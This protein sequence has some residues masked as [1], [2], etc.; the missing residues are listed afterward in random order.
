MVNCSKCNKK[1][2]FLSSKNNIKDGSILCNSCFEKW[3]KEQKDKDKRIMMD[4]IGK[5]LS[6]KDMEMDGY[7]LGCHKNKNI[8][9]LFEENSL[10]KVTEHFQTLLSDAEYSNKSGMSSYDIDEVISTKKMCE[11]VLKFL[12]DLEK[13]YKL[14]NK[15][16]I[17][18]NYFEILSL[19]AENIEQNLNKE[20]DKILIPAHKRIIKRLGKNISSENVIKEFMKIPLN[21]EY[22]FDLISKLLDKFNLEYDKEE[23]EKIIE[24]AREEIGL[25]EFEQDLGSSQK[26]DIGDFDKLNGY[27]FEG[28][29]K[30]L[31]NL[32]GYTTIQTALSGD[33]GADLIISKDG[34]KTVVQAKKYNEKVPNKAIQEIVAAKNH[35]KANKAIVITNSSFTKSAID[36]ALSNNVELWDG[37]KLKDIIQNLKNKKKEKSLQSNKSLTLQKGKDIQ[38]IKVSCPFCEEEF[39]LKIDIREGIHLETTCPHCGSTLGVSTDSKIWKCEYCPQQFDTKSEAEKHEKTCKKRRS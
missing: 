19:F 22:N 8:N 13:M 23:I 14:F 11:E 21:I 39:E 37:L 10:Q 7:I 25:E 29:L 4:Y 28:Y 1:L 31:F 33:Q 35:Y 3:K 12:E 26:I 16:G 5:Y 18:T 30:G 27:E 20:Y 6:N 38:K 2:G 24:D 15:K 32:L 17:D 34:E 9:D 36:L